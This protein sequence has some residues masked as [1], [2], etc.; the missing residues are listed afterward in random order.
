MDKYEKL[1]SLHLLFKD[2]VLTEEEYAIEKNKIMRG[3]SMTI[4]DM[5]SSAESIDDQGRAQPSGPTII[6]PQS[7]QGPPVQHT[8]IYPPPTQNKRANGVAIP[9]FIFALIGIIP[10]ATIV[11]TPIGIILCFIGV[12]LNGKKYKKGLAI[13]GLVIS[14]LTL[15]F[16][17]LVVFTVYNYSLDRGFNFY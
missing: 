17:V 4:N 5:Y 16:W 10:Y 1:R 2:G 12:A 7:H 15:C 3:S 8:I 13:A 11:F 6:R 9:G 14:L